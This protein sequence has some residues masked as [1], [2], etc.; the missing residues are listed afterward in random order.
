M[1]NLNNEIL[2]LNLK[3]IIHTKEKL[4]DQIIETPTI[5]LNSPYFKKI[6]PNSEIFMKLELFQHTGT[7]KARGALS[8]ASEIDKNKKKFGITA[9]SAGN[10]AIAASWAAKKLGMSAKVVMRSTAN[11]YR[12]KQVKNEDA[13]IIITDN[14]DEL[15][16]IAKKLVDKAFSV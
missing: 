7:F 12:L 9:A 10:H 3:S 2:R 16:K 6:N 13:E 8:A 11:P 5:K 1:E 4:K 14:L 15:F